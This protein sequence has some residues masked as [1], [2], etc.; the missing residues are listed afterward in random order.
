MHGPASSPFRAFVCEGVRPILLLGSLQS[1]MYVASLRDRVGAAVDCGDISRW[2]SDKGAESLQWHQWRGIVGDRSWQHQHGLL[3]W[4][5][6]FPRDCWTNSLLEILN[7]YL[8]HYH[9]QRISLK[10]LAQYLLWI[11]VIFG[12]R[13]VKGVVRSATTPHFLASE[14]FSPNCQSERL[15]NP[16]KLHPWSWQLT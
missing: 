14:S 5:Q 12:A 7:Q 16:T 6:Q 15:A 8:H 13:N 3:Q 9:K 1:G 10:L 2:E 4:L 11:E